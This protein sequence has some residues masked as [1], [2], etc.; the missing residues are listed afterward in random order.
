MSN[1]IK[2]EEKTIRLR[3]PK[4]FMIGRKNLLFAIDFVYGLCL[5]N[6]EFTRLQ[7]N[8]F[9]KDVYLVIKKNIRGDY[10][11]LSKIDGNITYAT[12][13]DKPFEDGN[14]A[15]T[16]IGR[17]IRRELGISADILSD[18][19][20]SYITDSFT[21]ATTK[22]T[23]TQIKILTGKAVQ[24]FYQKTHITS[25]MSGNNAF[26]TEFYANNPDKVALV[27][28]LDKA[29]ALLWTCDDGSKVL[30]RIYPVGSKYSGILNAWA[31]SNK[32]FVREDAFK[33]KKFF[34]TTKPK[35]YI[36]YM[37]TFKFAKLISDKKQIILSNSS[38]YNEGF[39]DL[40]AQVLQVNGKYVSPW[41]TLQICYMCK[42]VKYGKV[43]YAGR[44]V[45]DDCFKYYYSKCSVCGQ[46]KKNFSNNGTYG[47]RAN[48]GKFCESC[49]EKLSIACDSCH[50]LFLK[51]KD[52]M[53]N[54]KRPADKKTKCFC[55]NCTDNY[56]YIVQEIIKFDNKTG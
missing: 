41:N 35:D 9:Y 52:K 33:Q 56:C 45:C 30:D 46:K 10:V 11:S 22:P 44:Y 29:R 3:A 18:K 12:K 24:D 37:D 6:V 55:K 43:D 28:Y 38:D 25:C 26:L 47:F 19:F 39:S 4:A 21:E 15:T 17:Y 36:P 23:E 16:T 5:G 2:S 48:V 8:I 42:H 7:K 34:V 53:F 54:V 50:Y 51:S 1:N 32:Y 40:Y 49:G 31:L 20:I 27:V 14:R 13:K